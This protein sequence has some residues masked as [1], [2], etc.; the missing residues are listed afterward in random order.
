MT[1]QN[2]SKILDKY[3]LQYG[4]TRAQQFELLKGLPFYGWNI[5]EDRGNPHDVIDGRTFNNVIGLPLKNGQPSAAEER[6][7]N[8]PIRL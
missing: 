3:E 7:A 6:A 8:A 2:L 1:L 4:T 5:D